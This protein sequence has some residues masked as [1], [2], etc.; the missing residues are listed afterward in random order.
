MRKR[1]ARIGRYLR[2]QAAAALLILVPATAGA[3]SAEPLATR[4]DGAG[5][6][7]AALGEAYY[8]LGGDY[9]SLYYNPAGIGLARGIH[10]D[11]GFA[12]RSTTVNTRY[13]G[14][15][16]SINVGSTGLDAMGMTY[17]LPTDRGSLVFAVGAHRIRDLDNRYHVEGFNT[18]DDPLI[19]ETYV[20]SR[21]TDRGSL[22][23]YALGVSVETT[24]GFYF[25]ASLE[26]LSGTNSYNYIL[27][28]SDDDDIWLDW[29]GMY[30]EDGIDYT[31]RSRGLRIGLGG[32]WQPSPLLS[33]GGSIR[34][35]ARVDITEDWY[36]Y[37]ETYYDDDTWEVTWDESGVFEYNFELPFEFGIGGA[38]TLGG[39]TVTGGGTYVDY[40]QSEYSKPPYDDFDPDFFA[41]NYKALWRWGG[42]V[43]FAAPGGYALR[44]GYQWAPLQFHPAGQ[45]VTRDREVY[46]V[47]LGIPFDRS[48]RMDLAYQQSSWDLITDISR[49]RFKS[50]RFMFS[51]GYRF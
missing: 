7:A 50:G 35:P 20:W 36:E 48:L 31:Y 45:Q 4:P 6:R 42:G 41:N 33:L 44:A 28:A 25:G 37:D 38:V 24:K 51:F 49:D 17:A 27:D 47:G 21:N 19:G 40:S 1:D 18:S 32:L 8:A 30:R 29:A 3:Q 12:H 34:L 13:F 10:V 43:E 9:Y 14:T 15:P 22:Y 16:S 26:A 23:A 46:S 39:L 11:G 2:W 5:A